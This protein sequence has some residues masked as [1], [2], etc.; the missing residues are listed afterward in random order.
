MYTDPI[1]SSL[2]NLVIIF[3]SVCLYSVTYFA[4]YQYVYLKKVSI[5]NYKLKEITESKLYMKEMYQCSQ[6]L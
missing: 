5:T 3:C 2:E 1:F 4:S 6:P